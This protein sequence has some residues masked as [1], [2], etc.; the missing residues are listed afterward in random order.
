M[1]P[2]TNT[3][4]KIVMSLNRMIEKMDKRTIESIKQGTKMLA[5]FIVIGCVILGIHMGRKAAKTGG[6]QL[7]KGTNDIFEIDV[8]Q[9]TE[10]PWTATMVE[11]DKISENT[12]P[13][14]T[15]YLFPS[16]GDAE[17][18]VREGI[19]EPETPEHTK[20]GPA[21]VDSRDNLAEVDRTGDTPAK[22][23]VR[24]LQR[25]P[26][27]TDSTAPVTKAAADNPQREPADTSPEDIRARIRTNTD[28][29]N[30]ENA[31]GRKKPAILKSPGKV[32]PMESN[33]G[34]VE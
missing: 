13:G 33:R 23:D 25:T 14:L 7:V 22:S 16:S 4:F 28:S 21:A 31:A 20:T 30:T 8:K 6:I 9:S 11:S 2:V 15:R 32:S 27:D 18:Q 17:P 3:I 5:F 34:V 24:T 26:S 12:A 19:V 1:N 29:A 10:R